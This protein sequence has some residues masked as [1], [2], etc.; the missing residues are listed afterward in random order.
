MPGQAIFETAL[1]HCGIAWERGALVGVLLPEGSE[2]ATRARMRRLHPALRLVGI[3]DAPAYVRE[4]IARIAAMLGG[5]PDDLRDLPLDMTGVPAFHRRVYALVRDI[6]P[7]HTL[8]YGE[9]A[10]RL[11]DPTAARAVGQALGRNPFA[12]VIPC[13]RVLASGSRA[14]G[15]SAGGGVDT[16]LRMLQ[17]EGARMSREPGLFDGDPAAYR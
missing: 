17:A 15:F 6:A 10:A 16:K 1:G 4:A 12:P 13:H 11:G 5:E 2:E 9:V 8:T 3:V 14:G 7:G